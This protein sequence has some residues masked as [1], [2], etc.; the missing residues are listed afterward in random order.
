MRISNQ[1]CDISNNIGDSDYTWDESGNLVG[2]DWTDKELK[3]TLD[4]SGL[5][6]LKMLIV[7]IIC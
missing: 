5:D 6:S 2:I 3:G 7:T 4:L 1:V